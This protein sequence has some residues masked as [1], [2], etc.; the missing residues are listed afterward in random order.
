MNDRLGP[1]SDLEMMELRE[2][3]MG[4]VWSHMRAAGL[5]WGTVVDGHGFTG[6]TDHSP[7]HGYPD[8]EGADRALSCF[9]FPRRS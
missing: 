9:A 2:G 8:A 7:R 4:S 3:L 5:A 6:P 1:H